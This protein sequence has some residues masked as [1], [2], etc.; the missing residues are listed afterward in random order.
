MIGVVPSYQKIS[1]QTATE[2]YQTQ[3]VWL[4][5][6]TRAGQRFRHAVGACRKTTSR[7][8]SAI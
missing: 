2:L 4:L 7:R 6:F 8:S 3:T 5:C 1:F